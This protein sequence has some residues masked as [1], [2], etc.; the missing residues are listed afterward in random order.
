M[1]TQYL[2]KYFSMFSIIRFQGWQN[3]VL[4][5]YIVNNTFKQYIFPLFCYRIKSRIKTNL[6]QE[7]RYKIRY[8]N[9]TYS[10]QIYWTKE[11]NYRWNHLS[12]LHHP[13][14][15]SP[16]IFSVILLLLARYVTN[17]YIIFS[18][19]YSFLRVQIFLVLFKKRNN[20]VFF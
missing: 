1:L 20:V 16:N 5:I 8:Y 12:P 13:F 18:Y 4:L 11:S 7:C 15:I 19:K 3:G 10:S 14:S 9:F 17:F 6:S 2:K